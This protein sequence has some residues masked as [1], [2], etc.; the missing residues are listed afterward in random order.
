MGGVLAYWGRSSNDLEWERFQVPLP[1]KRT[2]DAGQGLL[3]RAFALF[4]S[5]FLPFSWQ[6]A[7]WHGGSGGLLL[8]FPGP[9]LEKGSPFLCVC[10]VGLEQVITGA[11]G[12]W[13]C[14]SFEISVLGMWHLFFF[15]SVQSCAPSCPRSRVEHSAVLRK[16]VPKLGL[17]RSV[18]GGCWVC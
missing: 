15:C 18:W 16:P 6:V 9:S 12:A 11:V 7:C 14:S 1:F 8:A 10:C 2:A 3:W 17:P 4:F 5:R 13:L